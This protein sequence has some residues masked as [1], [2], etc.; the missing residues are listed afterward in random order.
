[1]HVLFVHPNFPA[2]F[3]PLAFRLAA[4]PGTRCTFVTQKREGVVRGVRCLRYQTAGG[5]TAKTHYC[6]RTFENA[7]WHAAGVYEALAA[8]PD[9]R[10]DLVVGH[11]GFGSTLF[12]R[13]LYP[14]V[15]V[16]NLFEYFYRP[17]DSD[18]DFR[19]DFPPRP[20]DRLRARARNAMILLDLD[21]C[22]LGYCPTAWQLGRFPAEYRPKLRPLFDGIDTALWKPDPAAPRRVGGRAVPPGVRLVTYVSRGLESMRGFDVF[23]R[24]A[25]VVC[26][27]RA[28]V[29]FAVVG[30]DRVC[31]GGD[32]RFT[33]GKSFKEWVLAQDRYD[34]DRFVFT[35]RLPEAE[36]AALLAA[37][38]LHVYL[39]VPFV[40]SWSVLNA[41]ACGAVVLASDT[42]PVREVIEPGRTGL[43]APFFDPGA[44]A[45]AIGRV[46][47]DPPAY[48][49][50]G[51]AAAALVRERY[52]LDACVPGFLRL[53]ADARGR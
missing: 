16:V 14:G 19:P 30:E 15:P 27:R 29:L 37:T 31:Y 20:A 47:D 38:D 22:D 32:E 41:M 36:L 26:D 3:G 25:K 5:A 23:M 51:A 49:P 39:T 17:A 42:E 6:S 9:V 11:S 53:F 48:R 52:S 35:G 21:N 33:G 43:L 28:D 34:A 8:A 40:L 10:P 1:M 12:L 4:T 7:V 2:Q 13:D 44:F 24:A 18:L 46:L 45:D 50:L